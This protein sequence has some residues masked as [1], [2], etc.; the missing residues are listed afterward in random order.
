MAL[1]ITP[2]GERALIVTFGDTIDVRLAARA[3]A[4]ADAWEAERIGPA[5]PAYASAVLHFD[6]LRRPFTE[7][8]R[9]ARALA[10]RTAKAPRRRRRHIEIPVRY[11]G[12]DLAEVARLS[13]LSP[14]E[15][16]TLHT[17]RDYHAYFLGFV[18]G[19]A[20]LG[21]V[22]ARIV[23][24]RLEEPRPRV[25]A[26]SVA[27]AGGQTAVYPIETPGGWRLIGRT[28]VPMFDPGREPPSV[29]RAG[30]L[31]RFVALE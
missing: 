23:A 28:R 3:R 14:E 25:P 18:P 2:F 17:G 30:D 15:V 10:R 6:P 22:D 20:Y 5:I 7:V 4:L 13:R 9:A 1:R 26:G 29:I 31:V 11:D 21:N 27:V 12:D 16:V 24:P 8:V 19:F